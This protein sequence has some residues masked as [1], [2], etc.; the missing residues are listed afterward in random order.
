MPP[1]SRASAGV[2][3]VLFTLAGIPIRLH[4]SFFLVLPY[5]ALGMAEQFARFAD[6]A[7]VSPH[8]L[9]MPPLAW[10]AVLAVLLF[11]S[12]LLHELGHVFV[13]RARGARVHDVTLMLLGG[14]SRMHEVPRGGYDEARV[15]A[16]GPIVS[17][18]IGIAAFAAQPIVP[19]SL[20]DV[21]FGV[22][23]LGEINIALGIFNVLPAFPLDGG[24][25]LRALLS[26]RRGEARA[27]RIA[28]NVGK[29]F[30]AIMVVLGLLNAHLFL[31]L[32]GAFVWISGEGERRAAEMRGALAGVR[33]R[34]VVTEASA[35]DEFTTVEA[36]G[37]WMIDERRNALLVTDRA[38]NVGIVGIE[39]VAAVPKET[40]AAT[41]LRKIA[42][43][44][45]PILAAGDELP[46]ALE[47]LAAAGLEAAPVVED[48][49]VLGM[50]DVEEVTRRLR[51]EAAVEGANDARSAPLW[52]RA[53]RP[54][55]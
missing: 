21:R 6:E 34:S 9:T 5:L 18:V 51:L 24:R 17:F 32:I 2:G 25:V 20:P 37:A 52:S 10:G 3:I 50:L 8:A 38:G 27:T 48:G 35:L 46:A 41:P 53:A 1:P 11:A 30:A 29:V 28:A 26:I 54:S 43:Y 23:Y 19:S 15:A 14:V 16:I 44:D 12:V 13:A 49:V 45:V 40:R 55:R 42:R 4:W 39:A 31:V 47:Q 7:G 33:V 36:T 22:H